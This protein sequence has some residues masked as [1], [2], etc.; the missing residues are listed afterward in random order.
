VIGRL[1]GHAT[2]ATTAR[3]SH[4]GDDPLRRAVETIGSTI[5]GAMNRKAGTSVVRVK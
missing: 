5:D 2:P 4:L 1:L 3:Y